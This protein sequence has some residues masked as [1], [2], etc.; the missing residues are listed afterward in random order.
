MTFR[1]KKEFGQHFLRQVPKE[2]LFPLDY[3]EKIQS[4]QVP[5]TI[6]ILEIGPGSGV[7]TEAVTTQLRPFTK[8]RINYTVVDIDLEA[9]EA[10]KERLQSLDLPQRINVN[11]VLKDILTYK[12]ELAKNTDF[13]F[14]FGSLP[15]NISKKIV[16]ASKQVSL[17]IPK[18]V[19]MLPSRFVFQL[20]VAEDYIS[21]APKAAYLGAEL[22]LFA[23]SRR[24]TKKLPPGSFT[25]PPKVDSGILE[26]EWL[27]AKDEDKPAIQLLS[28][29]LRVGF[30][31]KRKVVGSIFKKQLKKENITP[32]IAHLLT[33][34]AHELSIGEWKLI[35]Q[36][37][38]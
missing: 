12:L 33:M 20:E 7:V 37:T 18:S 6:D 19:T 23:A 34:R 28:K 22:S 26:I 36:A 2:L 10:T 29:F 35:H 25:P 30:S 9:L 21:N 17:E 15:Y 24:I 14:I 3:L 1:Y 32:T 4:L 8:L 38:I 13:L 27:R 5:T 31:A 11:Y 16:N